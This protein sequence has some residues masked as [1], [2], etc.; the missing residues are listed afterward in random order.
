MWRLSRCIETCFECAQASSPCA[1]AFLDEDEVHNLAR[2]IS[3]DEV[4]ADVCG[5]HLNVGW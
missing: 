5:N 3:L 2:G 1:D 4:C